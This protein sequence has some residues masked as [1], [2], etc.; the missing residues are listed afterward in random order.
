VSMRRCWPAASSPAGSSLAPTWPASLR[1]R[2]AAAAAPAEPAGVFRLRADLGLP[3]RP[4]C[5]TGS[6]SPSITVAATPTSSASGRNYC[7]ITQSGTSKARCP[8]CREVLDVRPVLRQDL[9][10]NRAA[11]ATTRSASA[12]ETSPSATASSP[13]AT[14]AGWASRPVPIR[15]VPTARIIEW[16]PRGSMILF[17][18]AACRATCGCVVT[19]RRLTSRR[20]G[21][22]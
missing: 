17:L 21:T 6:S 8:T 3:G 18:R 15:R 20:H 13:C 12:G 19:R 4:R 9:S 7:R 16:Y 1:V 14:A 11:S 2:P 5:G 22:A 10:P